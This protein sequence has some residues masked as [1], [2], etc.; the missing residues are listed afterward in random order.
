MTEKHVHKFRRLRY[1]SG[2][3]IFFCTLPDCSAKINQSLALG[4][5]SI[6]WR[7]GEPF[8]M[9]EYSLRLAKPHCN[10]CHKPKNEIVPPTI[11]LSDRLQQITQPEEDEI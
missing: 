6:C 3:E 5:R 4:K 2:N 8:I 7:C 11:N 10:N 1:K 9:N